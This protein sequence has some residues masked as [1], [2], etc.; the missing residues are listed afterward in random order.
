[1]IR[2]CIESYKYVFYKWH[3]NTFASVNVFLKSLSLYKQQIRRP[4]FILFF[5]KHTNILKYCKT[6]TWFV[7]KCRINKLLLFI[8][9]RC[10]SYNTLKRKFCKYKFILNTFWNF[11]DNMIKFSYTSKILHIITYKSILGRDVSIQWSVTLIWHGLWTVMEQS[12]HT[13]PCFPILRGIGV[14]QASHSVPLESLKKKNVF[15]NDT[16]CLQP[17]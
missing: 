4:W 2:V 14:R 8:Y 9:C 6:V 12:L 17:K 16:Q 11:F 7:L 3:D 5:Y 15:D 10:S 1:M 13:Y